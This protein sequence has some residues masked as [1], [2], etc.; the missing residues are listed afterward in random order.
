MS[1]VAGGR[2]V[3]K[4]GT[5]R[6]AA[7]FG[8]L[9]ALCALLFAA[10]LA[11]G[12]VRI[13]AGEALRALF[14]GATVDAAIDPVVTI[15]R[16]FRLPKAIAAA[17][18]GAGLAVSGLLLQTVFRNPLA[19][20]DS[21]GIGAGASMGVAAMILATGSSGA[22]LIG[23]LPL[24]GYAAL[25]AAASLGAGAVL[26]L[27]LALSRKLEHGVTLLIAGLMVGYIAGSMVSLLVYFG[28][29]QKVQM[30]LGW[31][32][33][34]FAGVRNAELPAFALTIAAG[35]AL[36]AGSA[37]SLNALFMGERFASTLGVRVRGSRTRILAAAAILAGGVTAFC[38]PIAFLGIAAPQVARRLFRSSD[39]GILVPASALCGIAVALAADVAAQAPG[40]GAVLP[41]NPL[42][43]LFGAP[44]VLGMFLRSPSRVE[45]G[46]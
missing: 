4:A 24:T 15:M 26:A 37:K 12:S 20:P 8:S 11:L 32:Y 9:I 17:L 35:L 5:R 30:Y 41:I 36:T 13:P 25:A 23:A 14:G 39:H 38:G 45:T 21:L 2:T 31:T 16:M 34:S 33:G 18:A 10:D 27:I 19:G 7:V 22:A 46:K 40:G 44:V 42:L 28:S 1:E 29:P 3:G 43:A 6:N